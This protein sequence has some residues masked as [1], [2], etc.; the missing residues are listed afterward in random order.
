MSATAPQVRQPALALPAVA[1]IGLGLLALVAVFWPECRAAVKVWIDS[2][3][4]GHCF[5]VAP[6]AAYLAWDRRRA[7]AGLLPRPTPALAL[8]GLPLPLLWLAAQRLGIME[9][10]QLV[11]M[12]FVEL[13]FLAVLGWRLFRALSGPLLYLVF[14]VPFGAFITPAL[15]SVTAHFIDAGL[16]VLAIPH[17]SNDMY[18]EIPAGAFFVAEACAGLRFLIAAVAFGVFYALLNYRSTGRRVAFIAASVV[19]PIIANGLRA[20]G[21]VV[22]GHVLGSAE[23]AA[24][25]HLIYGWVFFSFVMLLLVAAGLPLREDPAPPPASAEAALDQAAFYP[26]PVVS[27][28]ALAALGP[29]LVL[30]LSY[31]RAP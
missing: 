5:L 19:I 11:A 6:L 27:V 26:W 10:R 14:L 28:V 17:F 13:L 22:L 20:L 1:A 31:A 24:A 2:T 7:L 25:D 9:G 30:A 29:A 4:Y 18:I 16:T 21:I 15:Q 3:A 8:A 23:A 12:G